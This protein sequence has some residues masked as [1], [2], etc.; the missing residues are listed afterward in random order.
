MM[1]FGRRWYF[2]CWAD[3]W[4]AAILF[5]TRLPWPKGWPVNFDRIA[6]WITL[7][8]LIL[9][10]ILW[11]IASCLQ[12]LGMANL[13]QAG[14]L[15]TAWLGLTGGLHLDG[16]ADSADGLA[17]TDRHRRLVVM[18]DSQ[19]GAYG[20]MAIAVVLL[21]KTLALAS[22]SSPSLATWA[23]VMAL[24]WGRWG[25][26]LA[27]ALY[28]YLKE[29][30]KGAMHRRSMKLA[31]DLLLGT[32]IIVIGSGIIGYGLGIV[33]W[34]MFGG[35]IGAALIAWAVGWWFA[36]QFGGHTG[37]TYGAVVEW[38]EVLILLGLTLV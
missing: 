10:A 13:L 12:W 23:L 8:G 32:G 31:P 6:R 11:L 24:G 3:S 2:F 5:Y 37:D 7:M 14:L 36:Q 30:G 29:T 35:T 26:L 16:V 18:Q 38:S 33:P 27:I 15:V 20:G 22:F 28:P 1:K 4:G 21:L 34:L 17:V 25:Q 9:W 19:M